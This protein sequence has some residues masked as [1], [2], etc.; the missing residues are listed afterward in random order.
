MPVI[1]GILKK[2]SRDRFEKSILF[3]LSSASFDG[4]DSSTAAG[5]TDLS[6]W[7]YS[8]KASQRS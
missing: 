5:K 6:K 2:G 4:F 8:Y 1:D 3:S 7:E